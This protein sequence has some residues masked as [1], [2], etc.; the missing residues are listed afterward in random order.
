MTS[1]K[2]ELGPQTAG[3]TES[4]RNAFGDLAMTDYTN[5][6]NG[7]NENH[8]R[9]TPSDLIERL[10]ITN[11]SA[12]REEPDLRGLGK[13]RPIRAHRSSIPPT[14]ARSGAPRAYLHLEC[15]RRPKRA[16]GA[17]DR[18]RVTSVQPRL[19]AFLTPIST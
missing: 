13:F 18:A 17:P 8:V 2:K 1:A 6:S 12:P 9:Q 19:R 11:N 4:P 10:G 3:T 14:L 7:C 15:L 5:G 16:R